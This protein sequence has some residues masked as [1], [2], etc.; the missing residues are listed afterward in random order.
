MM[1]Q[2][3]QLHS[4]PCK[5]PGSSNV[6]SNVDDIRGHPTVKDCSCSFECFMAIRLTQQNS[7]EQQT[8]WWSYHSPRLINSIRLQVSECRRSMH[9]FR[10]VLYLF[11]I[12]R[13]FR[14][15]S[16]LL[17]WMCR[18]VPIFPCTVAVIG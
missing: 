5:Q 15:S 6:I 9:T 14:I 2:K 1:T 4:T 8:I 17:G 7:S 13:F 3:I 10:F 18:L 12:R 16:F 11:N